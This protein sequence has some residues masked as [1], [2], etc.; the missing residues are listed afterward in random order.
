MSNYAQ[1][2]FF[3]PKDALPPSDPAKTIFGAAYDIEFGNIAT[4]IT[5]K[6]DSVLIASIPIAFNLGT[7]ALPGITFTGHTGTGLYS[8]GGGDLGLSAGGV[9]RIVI[10]ASTGTV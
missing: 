6:Y 9:S 8:N 4:A 2:T 3:T 10:S 1:T 5:S 7:V